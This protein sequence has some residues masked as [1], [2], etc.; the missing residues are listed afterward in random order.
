M[1]GVEPVAKP[2]PKV[3]VSRTKA[4]SRE[5]SQDRIKSS[6]SLHQLLNKDHLSR[7]IGVKK[8]TSK[9]KRAEVLEEDQ[10]MQK[11]M[12]KKKAIKTFGTTKVTPLP[13]TKLKKKPIV[14]QMN[15]TSVRGTRPQSSTPSDSS[16]LS[17]ARMTK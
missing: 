16:R 4:S 12:L 6:A 1:L 13:E 15:L 17:S 7:Q 10:I 14:I 8:E 11:Y 9:P 2:A 3:T 5:Q